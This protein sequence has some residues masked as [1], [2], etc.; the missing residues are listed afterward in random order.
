M[1]HVKILGLAAMA[2]L[3]LTAVAASSASATVLCTNEAAHQNGVLCAS[4]HGQTI[5]EKTPII[6]SLKTGTKAKLTATSS[7]GT[8]VATVEC[9]TSNVSGTMNPNGAGKINSF[10]FSNCASSSCPNGVTASTTASTSNEWT[11]TAAWTS[12]TSGTLTVNNVDGEFICGSIIGNVTCRYTAAS[13]SAAAASGTPATVTATNVS[14]TRTVGAESLCG[15]KADWSGTYVI[16][17]PSSLFIT[18]KD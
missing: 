18:E 9:S 6:A 14:L 1:K 7:K 17:T 15:A 4:P 8:S 13:A 16:T 11:A 2:V 5:K 10:T 12:G 3:A